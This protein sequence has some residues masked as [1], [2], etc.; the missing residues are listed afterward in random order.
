MAYEKGTKF[1]CQTFLLI[2]L[3]NSMQ[4]AVHEACKV[5]ACVLKH[6]ESVMRYLTVRMLPKVAA[7]YGFETE[8]MFHIHPVCKACVISNVQ[9]FSWE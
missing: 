6:S 9:R 1:L 5:S 4:S 2:V 8:L 7:D 3:I